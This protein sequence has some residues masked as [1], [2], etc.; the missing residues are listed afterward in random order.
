VSPTE[1]ID[2]LEA[3][4]ILIALK[5]KRRQ[6]TALVAMYRQLFNK[7]MLGDMS[8]AR[9]LVKLT[10]KYCPSEKMGTQDII[11]MVERPPRSGKMVRI[12]R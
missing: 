4:G 8:A 9:Q 2:R 12:A 7:T 11:W 1:E 10:M 3:E 5:G 6:V